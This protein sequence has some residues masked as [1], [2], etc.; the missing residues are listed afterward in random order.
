MPQT[1]DWTP[2]RSKDNVS[3]VYLYLC[4]TSHLL[5]EQMDVQIIGL[6]SYT[7]TARLEESDVH[8]SLQIRFN[9]SNVAC[10]INT[11]AKEL[12]DLEEK[13]I[14]LEDYVSNART[15][16]H[17]VFVRV[18]IYSIVLEVILVSYI[19]YQTRSV[20]T[21]YGKL[22]YASYLLL[23][24]LVIFIATKLFNALY[25][26][27]ISRNE[28]KLETLKSR[29]QSKIDERKKETDY[30]NTQKLIDKYD[31]L[32]KKNKGGGNNNFGIN[33]NNNHN[34]NNNLGIRQRNVQGQSSSSSNNTPSSPNRTGNSSSSSSSLSNNQPYQPYNPYQYPTS[35]SSPPQQ[36]QQQPPTQ[37]QSPQKP[38]APTRQT[39]SSS[40]SSSTLHNYG[41]QVQQSPGG[42]RNQAHTPPQKQN[43]SGWLDKVV[44]YLISDGPKYGSPLICKK[45]HS[46]NGYVPTGEISTVQ[47]RCRFCQ[48]FNQNG[49]VEDHD[50]DNNNNN[51]PSPSSS[52]SNQQP[53]N[54][55]NNNEETSSSSSSSTPTSTSQPTAAAAVSKSKG[56]NEEKQST[57]NN[58]M[59]K[60]K[61]SSSLQDK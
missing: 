25:K 59:K 7:T 55:N 33:N 49:L 9:Y 1:L 37:Y 15:T 17:T 26:K 47:F 30:E 40:S 19:Y 13:I 44:D 45:C 52:L 34:N 36:Q 28:K 51:N 23:F 58:S 11:F 3:M 21:L 4:I 46:H 35:P 29:L 54:N 12:A 50:G 48:Y 8:S 41:Q 20:E 31:K 22:L 18:I 10:N 42:M 2:Y 43:P 6:I 57:P 5:Q 24:P 16:Q 32:M 56:G 61:S 14:H 53:N 38:S 27:I 39:P 60:I